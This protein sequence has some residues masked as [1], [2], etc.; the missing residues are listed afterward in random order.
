[1]CNERIGCAI[2]CGLEHQFVAKV[3]KL[4]PPLEA[5][6]NRPASRRE[7]PQEFVHCWM[8]NP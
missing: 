8:L 5:Y 4:R 7:S 6:L 1:M 2:D 3:R